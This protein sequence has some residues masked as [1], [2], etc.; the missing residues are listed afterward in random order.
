MKR[1]V[2]CPGVFDLLHEGH[3][4][5]LRRASEVGDYLVAAVVSDRGTEAYKGRRPVESERQRMEKVG[6]LP[7]V[8]LVVLQ[9]GTD[10]TGALEALSW[11]GIRP[12]VLVHADDW[13]RLKE[14]HETLEAMGIEYVTFP[15]TPG[16]S[17]TL[18]REAMGC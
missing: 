18:L 13:P 11:L 17:T 9:H 16:V 5:I 4:N 10:P 8:D 1:I 14:G 15:Y 12:D 7:F 6:A 3:R 2:Y